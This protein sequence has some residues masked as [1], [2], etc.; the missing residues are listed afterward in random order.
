MPCYFRGEE[1]DSAGS[2]GGEQRARVVRVSGACVEKR[3]T[4]GPMNA[5]RERET[6]RWVPH[7]S[8]ASSASNALAWAARRGNAKL[9]RIGSSRPR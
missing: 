5:E 6:A 7:V 2:G 8:G 9:G 3:Q 4:S 1:E